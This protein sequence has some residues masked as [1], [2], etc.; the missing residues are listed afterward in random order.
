MEEWCSSRRNELEGSSELFLEALFTIEF[1]PP[2][3]SPCA[4]VESMLGLDNEASPS[5]WG[6]GDKQMRREKE[7]QTQQ[8]KP[9][10]SLLK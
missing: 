3:L 8:L 5:G 10:A 6:K 1:T 7:R 9:A 2:Y 4:M